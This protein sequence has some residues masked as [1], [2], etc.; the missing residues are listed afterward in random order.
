[1]DLSTIKALS[2]P[3]KL[4]YLCSSDGLD[5]LHQW[6]SAGLSLHRIA[7]MLQ[8][9]SSTLYKL[10]DS[11]PEIIA[12]TGRTPVEKVDHTRPTAYRIVTGYSFHSKHRGQII[13]EYE[14]AEELWQS[15]FI[16]CYFK[17]Y[18][19]SEQDYLHSYLIKIKNSGFCQL[20]NIYSTAYCDVNRRGI[21]K[22]L[23]P[24]L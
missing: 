12:I 21:I 22:I 24:T 18:G 14:T 13:G 15:N 20:S 10:C 3:D 4:K 2:T 1:M 6:L 16:R 11:A 9:K 23:K 17:S 5:Q 7:P 19:R 8:I